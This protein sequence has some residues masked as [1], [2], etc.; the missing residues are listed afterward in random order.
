MFQRYLLNASCCPLSCCPMDW[1]ASVCDSS[2][3]SAFRFTRVHSHTV[4][5]VVSRIRGT[6]FHRGLVA[7]LGRCGVI[8][9]APAR[10]CCNASTIAAMLTQ[11]I[12]TIFDQSFTRRTSAI[13]AASGFA[14]DTPFEIGSHV[15]SHS[16]LQG[17]CGEG[18]FLRR[19][20]EQIVAAIVPV[21][22]DDIVDA[23]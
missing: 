18:L 11:V 14:E 9:V 2:A 8:F 21:R 12:S 4:P 20:H 5:P 19:D 10:A 23:P 17:M 6:K 1:V 7:K 16:A 22:F 13:P 3:G 15:P